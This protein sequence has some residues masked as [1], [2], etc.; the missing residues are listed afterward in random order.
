MKA[1]LTRHCMC[2]KYISVIYTSGMYYVLYKP[3]HDKNSIQYVEAII[4]F[5]HTLNLSSCKRIQE[6]DLANKF[7]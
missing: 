5:I 4:F 3:L 7:S 2:S 1:S 6:I